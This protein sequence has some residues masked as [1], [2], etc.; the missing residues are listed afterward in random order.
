VPAQEPPRPETA[1]V[2]V[3]EAAEVPEEPLPVAGPAS[4]MTFDEAQ[5]LRRLLSMA[6]TADECRLLVD[7][8]LVRS[9]YPV[10]M[11]TGA[12]APTIPQEP[13]AAPSNLEDEASKIASSNIDLERS[14]VMHYLGGYD[15]TIEESASGAPTAEDDASESISSV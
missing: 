1:E 11:D 15:D 3:A 13:E 7:M 14:L 5:D 9:G 12:S 6:T 4:G 10:L 8:F 2:P